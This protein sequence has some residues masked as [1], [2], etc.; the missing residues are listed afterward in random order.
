MRRMPLDQRGD[1]NFPGSMVAV[2]VYRP[3]LT[4]HVSE[5]TKVFFLREQPFDTGDIVY[6]NC[7][8]RGW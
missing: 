6:A 1:N 3:V 8:N 5:R 4:L 7:N 2:G